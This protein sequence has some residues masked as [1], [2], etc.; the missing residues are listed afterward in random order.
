MIAKTLLFLAAASLLAA[1]PPGGTYS[2]PN[3]NTLRITSPFSSPPSEGLYPVI[4]EMTSQS[5]AARWSV[6]QN[7]FGYGVYR[8]N[9]VFE[10]P[11]GETRRAVVLLGSSGTGNSYMDGINLEIITVGVRDSLRMERTGQG[12]GLDDT[13]VGE[14]ALSDLS[15]HL[16]RT[17]V[18]EFTTG[19]APTDWRAYAG[20]RSVVVSDQEWRGMDPGARVAIGH[21]A[22]NGGIVVVI[23][24]DETAASTLPGFPKPDDPNRPG[25]VGLGKALTILKADAN[26]KTLMAAINKS[27]TMAFSSG[28]SEDRVGEWRRNAPEFFPQKSSTLTSLLMLVVLV[29]FAILI[30][31]VNL[32]VLAPAK[33]RHR[34]FFSVPVIALS[35]S[36]LLLIFV[37]LSDGL[38][39]KGHRFLLIE[40]R[41]GDGEAVNHV[42][43]YQTSRCGVLFS[44]GFTSAVSATIQDLGNDGRN[45]RRAASGESKELIAETDNLEGNGAWFVSRTSQNYRVAA[46]VPGRG[47]IE[48]RGTGASAKLTSTFAFPL[49]ALWFR[50]AGGNWWKTGPL[51]MGEPVG[52]EAVAA[53]EPRTE[54]MERLR[55][56]PTEITNRANDAA[57]RRGSFIAFT[58]EPEAVATHSSIR[59]TDQAVVTGPLFHP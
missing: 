48:I 38:G 9:M 2:D 35:T 42:V 32:F 43:Q 10:C 37:L 13:L 3:G 30:G 34:L 1:A 50:D 51:K 28:S 45:F 23:V 29:A 24:P 25:Q 5:K 21:Y 33:R 58:T 11:P 4:V 44:T 54:W 18:I 7:T 14:K 20:Y 55:K 52:V 12:P 36:A 17:T 8:R 41:P 19:L 59:W 40:N 49:E 56:A 57:Q 6:N 15:N 46:T 27:G 16:H 22:K 47:R 31:P 39:G 26:D 53:T